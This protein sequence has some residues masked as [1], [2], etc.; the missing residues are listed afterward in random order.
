MLSY[1]TIEATNVANTASMRHDDPSHLTERGTRQA[2][3]A[4]A[5]LASE[6]IDLVFSSDFVRTKETAEIIAK[7]LAP[8]FNEYDVVNIEKYRTYVKLLIDNTAAPA[9]DM[10]I[11]PP[12]PGNLELARAIKELSRLKYGR[13]RSEV[14]S[15]ILERTRLG[16]STRM[17]DF[18]AIE[19]SL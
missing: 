16:S 7:E 5:R 18:G 13:P 6:K 19:A 4:A 1:F 10:E 17:A 9:F 15:E 2:K 8:I 3:E 12:R 14:E 11:F